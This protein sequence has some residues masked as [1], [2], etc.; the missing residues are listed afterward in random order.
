[1]QNC[2]T[3]HIGDEDNS[4]ESDENSSVDDLNIETN[5]M[6]ADRFLPPPSPF[7]MEATD[8]YN[9]W[10]Q[11]SNAFHIYATATELSKK[12]DE[13]QRA[14]M[15]HC[16]GLTVQRIFD[17]LPGERT[18]LLAATQALEGCSVLAYIIISIPYMV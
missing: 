6:A 12:A 14:T 15:L 9:E 16:L 17:T 7:N 3:Q 8:L 11:W 5:D 10:K 18:T 13:I 1:M 2:S 4:N